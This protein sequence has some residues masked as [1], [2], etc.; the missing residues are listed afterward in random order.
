[1]KKFLLVALSVAL[2]FSTQSQIIINNLADPYTQD[3][4]TLA[5][6][7][8][9]SV[10]P[11]GWALLE[12]GNNADI[13]YLADNGTANSGNTYSYGAANNAERAFGS[14]LSGSLTPT[15]GVQFTNNSGATITSIT[16]SYTGEQWRLGT[17]NREDRLDFQY[18][19]NATALNN[20]VYTDVNQLDFIAPVTVVP[21]GALDGNALANKKNIAAFEIVGLNIPDGSSFWFRWM[22]FNAAG[23]D[24]GLSIDDFTVTFNGNANPPCVEPLAQPTN[25]ILNPT[26]TTITGSFTASVPPADE[27]LVV[28]SLVALLGDSPAD[29]VNYAPGQALG[30][31]TVV[32]VSSSTDFNAVG[33]LPNTQYFFTVFALNNENCGGGPNYNVT[34][35]LE[36]STNTLP[37]PACVAPLNPPTNLLLN[38]GKTSISGSFT[39][40]D[41]ANRY[42]VVRSQNNNL[43]FV[44]QN[45][46]TYAPGQVIG[47][48]VIVS[49]NSNINFNAGGLAANTQY[50]FFVFAA[51][52]ECNGEPFYNTVSLDGSASTQDAP[53]IPPAYYSGADGLACQPLK[54][55]LKVAISSNAAVLSYT[56]GLWNAYKYTDLHKDDDNINDIIWDMYSDNP[57]GPEPYTYTYIV[58]QCGNYNNEGDCYNREHSMPQS[59][60]NNLLPMKTDIHHVFPTDGKVNALRNNY[61]YGEVQNIVPVPGFN[62]PSLNGSKLGTGANFGYNGTVFEPINDYKGDFARAQ[63]YMATRYEDEIIANNWSANGNANEVLLSAADEPNAAKRRLE[64]YDSWYIKL[65]FKWHIQDPVSQKE[66]DRNNAIY[67]QD[68]ND[69]GVF[70]R[71]GNRNPF[72]DHPEYVAAIWNCSGL[73]PVTITDFSVSKNSNGAL[74]KWTATQETNFKLYEVEQSTDGVNYSKIGEVKGNNLSNYSFTVNNLPKTK[75]VF[76][77]LRM[78][79]IDSKFS[80]S[81]TVALQL[82]IS[83][84]VVKVYPNPAIGNVTIELEKGL[85]LN[86]DIKILDL[87]GRVVLQQKINAGQTNINLSVSNLSA[88]RYFIKIANSTETINQSFSIVK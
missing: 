38:P 22:D 82:N 55:A 81:K 66:I 4:N 28:R 46:V 58:K 65:L 39:A 74:L 79:D 24:D 7:G 47:V 13:N 44:P 3:F 25:L 37:L 18:S 35:P 12:T 69:G 42:L 31:G 52:G 10:L 32:S 29:G 70:K 27:Y 51:N 77:R 21:L 50:F 59:W 33:L 68:V 34:N 26:P 84:A 19:T 15:I 75:V 87:T 5:S 80:L 6:A 1:M 54:T 53:G 45:G 2:F 71:Q 86:S 43:G 41:N 40:A 83:P 64:I 23:A 49:Y 88:G 61:P 9:S 16:V 76:Y 36:L 20:G 30:N 63:L 72:V 60:F 56:P 85:S 73:L 67:Y 8:T 17:A 14:I 62:N 11:T 78:I 48:D 57:N